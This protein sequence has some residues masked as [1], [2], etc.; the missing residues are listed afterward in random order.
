V[1]NFTVYRKKAKLPFEEKS[2][3][4]I[5]NFQNNKH[6]YLIHASSDIGFKGTVLNWAM[7]TRL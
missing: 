1:F 3:V 6:R 4:E 7:P 5:I 2:Q